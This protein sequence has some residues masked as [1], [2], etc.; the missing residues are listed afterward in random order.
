MIKN[1]HING[2]YVF[3]VCVCVWEGVVYGKHCLTSQVTGCAVGSDIASPMLV[4]AT[5]ANGSMDWKENL[6]EKN[7]KPG[8]SNHTI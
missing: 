6:Q 4:A 5:F 1:M 7:G 8:S 3:N 2:V